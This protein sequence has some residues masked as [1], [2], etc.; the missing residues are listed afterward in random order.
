MSRRKTAPWTVELSRQK[1]ASQV[2]ARC[3][4][5]D[6]AVAAIEHV[7]LKDGESLTLLERGI[8][9]RMRGRNLA[10]SELPEIPF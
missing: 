5:R 1:G 9:R 10:V 7:E 4:L 8:V 2:I 3:W 6:A